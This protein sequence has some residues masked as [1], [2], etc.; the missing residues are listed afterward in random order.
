MAQQEFVGNWQMGKVL[1]IGTVGT[2]YQVEHLKTGQVGALKIL[3]PQVSRDELIASRFAREI[4]ILQR[5]SHPN[6]VR[7]YESGKHGDR[8]YYVM[9]LVDNGTLKQ[10]LGRKGVINWQDAVEISWQLCSALQHLH[11]NGIIH[12]DLK[13]ANIFFT[14]DGKAKLGDF[15]IALDT[16]EA[17]LTHTGVTV[18][19]FQYM[20]PEQIRGDRAIT[21]QSDLY[22]L[23]CLTYEMLAG[24]PPFRGG[25]FARI[26]DQHLQATA[27]PVESLSPATPHE[28]SDLIDQMLAKK[29]EQRPFNARAVQG[30]LAEILMKWDEQ[31]TSNDEQKR[32][33]RRPDIWA[34]RQRQTI[35]AN[36][37]DEGRTEYRGANGWTALALLTAMALFFMG[38]GWV[39]ARW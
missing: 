9:E 4:D 6:I 22:A 13:P 26:F 21:S 8:Y 12:R 23:G 30:Q 34:I 29:P 2:V 7:L 27:L 19:T 37:L 5:L 10:L 28:F 39:A 31:Q 1:G 18:G 3:L 20:S 38:F 36:L 17:D 32:K 15:G 16:A 35:L 14:R 25:N 11:N 33:K 24:R